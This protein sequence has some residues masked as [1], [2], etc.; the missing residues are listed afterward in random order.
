MDDFGVSEWDNKPSDIP[1]E[2]EIPL[3]GERSEVALS[4][5]NDEMDHT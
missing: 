4:C 1:T 3:G 5:P 2:Q